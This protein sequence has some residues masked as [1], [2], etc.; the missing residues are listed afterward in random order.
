MTS[1]GCG[2]ECAACITRL[3]AGLEAICSLLADRL[4]C[5]W[6]HLVEVAR[7]VIFEQTPSLYHLFVFGLAH[8]EI[9]HYFFTEVSTY[10]SSLICLPEAPCVLAKSLP[11]CPTLCDRTNYSPPGPSVHGIL[12]ARTLERLPCLLQGTF[13]TRESNLRLLWLLCWQVGSLP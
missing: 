6:A 10:L 5:L 9:S 11:S 13:L 3:D 2:P 8:L 4:H 12:Q 7:R 1:C